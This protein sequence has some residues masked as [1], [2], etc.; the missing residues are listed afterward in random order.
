MTLVV[1]STLKVWDPTQPINGL[2]Y[3][4][5]IENA[6]SA[7]QLAAIG[8]AKAVPFSVPSFQVVTGPATYQLQ[9]QNIVETYPTRAFTWQEVRAERNNRL[10]A[11][12]WVSLPDAKPTGPNLSDWKQYRQALRD[13]PQNFATSDAVVWP[14]APNYLKQ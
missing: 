7:A 12:D 5:T 10:A 8:L 1:I 11:T 3:P 4:P 6:Y 13:I 14:S 9:G 2:R